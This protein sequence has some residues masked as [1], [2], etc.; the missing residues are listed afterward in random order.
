M[1]NKMKNNEMSSA[2]ADFQANEKE[3]PLIPKV[4][5]DSNAQ[6]GIKRNFFQKHLIKFWLF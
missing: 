2:K 3:L 5:N 1:F 4:R 6:H